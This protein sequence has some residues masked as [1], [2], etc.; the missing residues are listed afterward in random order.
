MHPPEH[1]RALIL[2]MHPD[3]PGLPL[4]T[5]PGLPERPFEQLAEPLRTKAQKPLGPARL[6]RALGGNVKHL[7]ILIFFAPD[8]IQY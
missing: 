7:K 3:G 2:R 8:N 6:P 4:V 5:G 1:T